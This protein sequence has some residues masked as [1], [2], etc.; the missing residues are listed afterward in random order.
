MAR[1]G[2]WTS[3]VTPELVVGAATTPSAVWAQDGVTW[4]SE[5]RPAEGGR[6]QIVRWV[7]GGEPEDVLPEGFNAR[8]R[9]HEY[10]GGAWWVHDGT[11]FTANFADQRLYR[12]DPGV[13]APTPITPEPPTPG[14]WRY[15]DGRVTPDGRWIVC[16]RERHEGPDPATDVHNEL[17]ALPTD[18]SAAPHV[19]FSGRDFVA[20]PRISRDGRQLAWITWDHPN[21]S[22]DDAD[23]MI[24]TLEESDGGLAV[25]A[26]Q[27][28]AGAPQES[29]M[30]P[31]W[32]RRS[33]LHVISDRTGWWNV[34]RVDGRDHLTNLYPIEREVGG[35][36]WVFGQESIATTREG[37]VWAATSDQGRAVLVQ[38][39]EEGAAV[40]HALACMSLRCLVADGHRLVA[41]ATYT[42]R[43]AEVVEIQ[44][45]NP[46]ELH[47][48]R[49]APGPG[50]RPEQVSRPRRVSFGSGDRTAYA[51]Y[52]PPTNPDVAAP[53][54]ERPPLI[55]TLHGGPTSA[56]DPSFNAEV[57][58]WTSRGFAWVSVDYA[59]S[60][61]LGRA[62]RDSLR[63]N[64]GELDV[65]DA[66]AAAEH[67]VAE[68]LAD[69]ER[70]VIRGGSAGGFTVLATLARRDTFRAGINYFGVSDLA[71]LARDTHKFESRYL[72]RM[73]GPL[74]EAAEVYA[75]RSPLSHLDG[76]TRPLLTLQGLDDRVVPPAQSEQIVAALAA[77]GVPHAYVTFAG[78]GH[79]FRRAE[80]RIAALNAEL[81]F[82]GQVFDF[83]PADEVE[84][85]ELVHG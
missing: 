80:N 11:V 27:R 74:P 53:D 38:I 36:A 8:T 7:A 77:R 21:M 10:G 17:V 15:A 16:V 82:L 40:E 43:A 44:A 28:E 12:I 65:A 71:A 3:E 6:E 39:P 60:T 9:V 75:A 20:A 49:P 54:D 26:L 37:T 61:G 46:T 4:C 51:W 70:L 35:P 24:G 18:G 32:G 83:T 58:F 5:S 64:W 79:G 52:Y 73:V 34:H 23:L 85:L 81:S 30:A 62:Y 45:A 13:S 59:G 57:Q 25:V 41:I 72:D 69:A 31:L 42:D 56:A 63:G 66:C 47:V 76:F 55:V 84:P 2:T 67:L 29:L 68:G 48:L 78:E 19:V 14:A 22:W 1:Y 50:L 33:A